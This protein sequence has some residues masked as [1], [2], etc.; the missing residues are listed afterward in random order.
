MIGFKYNNEIYYYQ[1][2]YQNDITGI[3]DSSYNLV[4]IYTYD[5]WGKIL[6]VKDNNNE[7]TDKNH[8]GIINPYRFRSYYYDE[9]TSLYYLNSRYYNPKWC[10]FINADGIIGANQD[11]MSLNLY[12]YVSNNPCNGIDKHG[13]V[14]FRILFSIAV[15]KLKNTMKM[16][17]KSIFERKDEE[18]YDSKSLLS[19]TIKKSKTTKNIINTNLEDFKNS[20][21]KSKSYSSTGPTNFYGD[22]SDIDLALSVG[23]FNYDMTIT[24][25]EKNFVVDMT[26]SDTYNFELWSKDR[27][28]ALI[29]NMGFVLQ[30]IGII[31]PYYWES[32]F[33]IVVPKD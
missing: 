24:D 16:F 22:F 21:Q 26:I 9:E 20:S 7:I 11:I 23:S 15:T 6:S 18:K 4:V 10:R 17:S 31:H 8:I 32:N 3:Y 2:N 12:A 27:N 25:E 28:F 33:Q 29:N 5:A 1:K 19:K 13:T 14:I 30:D